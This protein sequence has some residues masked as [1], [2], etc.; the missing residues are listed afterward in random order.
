MWSGDIA[1]RIPNID[2]IR[3]SVVSFTLQPLH[4]QRKSLFYFLG[5]RLEWAPELVW[6]L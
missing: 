6:M 1:P 2:T 5:R 3:K 4:S